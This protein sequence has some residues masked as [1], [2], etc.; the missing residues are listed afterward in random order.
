LEKTPVREI[1]WVENIDIIL[2]EKNV[3]MVDGWNSL[4]D[5]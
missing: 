3:V 5:G 4:I 2:M 1:R